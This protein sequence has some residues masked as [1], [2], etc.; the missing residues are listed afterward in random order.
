MFQIDYPQ[1]IGL[2]EYIE[3]LIEIIQFSLAIHQTTEST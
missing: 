3:E 2:T 1:P